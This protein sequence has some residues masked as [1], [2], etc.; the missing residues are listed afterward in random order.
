MT[1]G[2]EL[3]RELISYFGEKREVIRKRWVEAMQAKNLLTGLTDEEL[4]TESGNIYDVCV[5]CIGTG[6]F[7]GAQ[8][9]AKRMAEQSVLAG[10][11]SEQMTMGMLALKDVYGRVVFDNY[12]KDPEGW[13]KVLDTYEPAAN[14]ILGIVSQAFVKE[15]EK[16]IQRQQ[17]TLRKRVK[18]LTC[19]HKVNRSMQEPLCLED[20]CRRI[21]QFLVSAMQFPEITAVVIE[22]DGRRYTSER[23]T[24]RLSHGLHAEIRVGEKPLGCLSVY[25]TEDKSFLIPEEQDLLETIGQDLGLWLEDKET[26]EKLQKALEGTIQALGQTT[27]TRDPYTA[28]H[29]RRVTQLACAIAEEMDVSSEQIEGI[30]VAGLMHDIGKISV[31]AEILSKPSQLT[32]TEFSLIKAHPQGA[33]D[34]LKTIDFPWPVANIVFQHHERLDGSGY[35]HALKGEDII[36]EARILAVADVVEAMVSHRP[37]RPA[38]GI[39]KALEELSDNKGVKYDSE[40]VNACLKLFAEGGFEFD[41]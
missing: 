12:G 36:L 39:D 26:E 10:M 33:Y 3:L 32:D 8:V 5:E 21:I 24:E 16:S 35:P 13:A 14:T 27:E 41:T 34:I 18:E 37:Y 6:K 4:E 19:L 9:Y 7:D 38:L 28:G 17:E 31:P 2:E 25:Y 22:L 11:T 30:R 1:K 20:L 23:Y 40:V 29:Q 15:R